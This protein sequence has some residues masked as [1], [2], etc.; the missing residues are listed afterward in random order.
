MF[1]EGLQ[2][3]ESAEV[4]L[5]LT[6]VLAWVFLGEFQPVHR[7]PVILDCP[8]ADLDY[9]LLVLPEALEFPL[10]PHDHPHSVQVLVEVRVVAIWNLAV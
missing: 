10:L 6:I 3:V 4:D 7:V 1:A 9:F 8:V 5:G 2:L